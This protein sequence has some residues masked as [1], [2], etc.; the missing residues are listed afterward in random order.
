MGA[1][2]NIENAGYLAMKAGCDL[3]L[4][5]TEV[6]PVLESAIKQIKEDELFALQIEASV[7]RILLLK[8]LQGL[9]DQ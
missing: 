2:V 6:A 8:Y 1:V 5:P 4:M 9:F 7:K 3:I